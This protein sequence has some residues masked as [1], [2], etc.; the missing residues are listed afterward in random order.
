MKQVIETLRPL[1][2]LILFIKD[3]KLFR[4]DVN[5]DIYA[6]EEGGQEKARRRMMMAG[7]AFVFLQQHFADD[8]RV[9]SD[10][11]Q[12]SRFSGRAKPEGY[13]PESW[14][15]DIMASAKGIFIHPDGTVLEQGRE[16]GKG[17]RPLAIERKSI[18]T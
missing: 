4:S 3:E 15:P 12:V 16:M 8:Y 14:E 7:K 13:E 18:F 11:G 9:T 17:V 10:I 2:P 6:Q 1:R 5:P